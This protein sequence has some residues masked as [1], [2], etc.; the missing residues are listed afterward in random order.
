[1]ER[2]QRIADD[3][4]GMRAMYERACELEARFRSAS[5]QEVIAMWGAGRNEKGEPLDAFQLEA[6]AERW[7]T[8]F[9][10][11]PPF[12]D[13]DGGNDAKAP[14]E[15]ADDTIIHKPEVLRQ[16]GISQSSLYRMT[17]DG[18]F[19]TAMQLSERRVGWKAGDI[20]AWLEERP[21]QRVFRRRPLRR[22]GT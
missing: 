17:R 10:F 8:L 4:D 9:G 21:R 19:L 15:P 22:K 5:E 16:T 12:D 18:R 7:H 14:D 6:L 1:M 20:K 11:E 13:A 3:R 2:A